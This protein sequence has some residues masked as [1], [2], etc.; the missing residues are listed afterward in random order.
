MITTQPW[1][2]PDTDNTSDAEA[3]SA[4]GH[5]DKFHEECGVVGVWN[6]T[7]AAA[8]A[9]L[10]LHALQHRG[11]EA[12]GIVCY[13]GQRFHAHKGMGLVGDVFAD[14]RVMATLKG[15]SAIG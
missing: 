14:T 9:A 2:R 12:T 7:D 10:G 6:M 1:A 4:A 11:Q 8:V 13:D 3:G 5:D 15:S